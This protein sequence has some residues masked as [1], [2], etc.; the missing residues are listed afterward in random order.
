MFTK[1]TTDF[2]NDFKSKAEKKIR[3]EL[4][5]EVRN[6][7]G[8]ELNAQYTLEL[9]VKEAKLREEFERNIETQVNTVKNDKNQMEIKLA[10]LKAQLITSEENIKLKL[11]KEFD[12][13]LNFAMQNEKNAKRTIENELIEFKT[14]LKTEVENASIKAEQ[15][16]QQKENELR[17]VIDKLEAA[18]LVAEAN[19][20]NLETQLNQQKQA[21]DSQ[22]ESQLV[23]QEK[24]IKLQFEEV[25]K[26]KELEINELKI[27][28]ATNRIMNNKIKGENWEHEIEASLRKL[29]L[30]TGDVIEKIT[31]GGLKA[32]FRQIVRNDGK[33]VDRIIYEC[34]NAEWKDSW[35]TKFS[36]DI[37]REKATYGIL[38]ATSTEDKFQTP[39]L[40]SSKNKNIFITGPDSFELISVLVRKLVTIENTFKHD[41]Q[42][43]R[44]EQLH[45]WLNGSFATFNSI[46]EK[47]IGTISAS[48]KT[49]KN[50]VAD[51]EKSR[52]TLAK[53]WEELV[54]G[55]L[56]GFKI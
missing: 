39:F 16:S 51:I 30:G 3:E 55:F 44:I 34:K 28:N 40:I 18:K 9:S 21:L 4:E 12:D 54:I 20:K 15:Q 37:I 22:W 47:M 38:V 11:Q 56:D 43:D 45:N 48:E 36:E 31:Q 42:D 41:A 52:E 27:A 14:R 32:D 17:A 25:L 2:E 35:E 10:E 33:D 5:R 13:K 8:K 1:L 29:A 49:I 19:F 23:K 6:T 50:K 46:F 7:V 24:D 53:K 26:A